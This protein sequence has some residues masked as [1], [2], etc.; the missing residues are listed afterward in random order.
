MAP[1]AGLLMVQQGAHGSGTC[2]GAG[3]GGG[4]EA[5]TGVLAGRRL[6]GEMGGSW[7]VEGTEVVLSDS[8]HGC[9][10]EQQPVSGSWGSPS[11]WNP[12]MVLL[13][14]HW[15]RTTHGA[16]SHSTNR[17]VPVP[18]WHQALS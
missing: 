5:G 15:L 4:A 9:R 10:A 14:P 2:Q 7:G 1:L 16:L 6:A 11:L 17:Y 3:G 8:V 12:N 13:V 18:S